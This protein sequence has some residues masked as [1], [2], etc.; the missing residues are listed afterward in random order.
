M[1]PISTEAGQK[2]MDDISN[3]SDDRNFSDE[4]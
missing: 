4:G 2:I 1:S 3:D